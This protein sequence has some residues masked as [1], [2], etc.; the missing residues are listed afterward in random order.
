MPPG[1]GAITACMTL[2]TPHKWGGMLIPGVD[3]VTEPVFKYFHIIDMLTSKRPSF[4]DPLH[5]FSHIQPGAGVGRREQ[6]DALLSAPL[7]DAVAFMSSQII[8]DQQH[9]HR[10]EKAIQ[11][12]GGWVDIPILPASP[13]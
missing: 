6:E 9:P 1:I 5:G 13:F 4:D 11:L 12:L 10:R 3:S 2:V 8:P 7:H